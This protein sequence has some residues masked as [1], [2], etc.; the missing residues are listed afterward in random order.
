MEEGELYCKEKKVREEGSEVAGEVAILDYSDDERELFDEMRVRG[1]HFYFAKVLPIENPKMDAMIKKAE[2]TIEKINRDQVVMTQKIRERMMDRDALRSKLNRMNCG[3]YELALKWKRNSLDFLYPSLDKLT[4]ANNAYRGKSVNSCLSVGEVDKQKLCFLMVHGCKNMGD[5]RKL[6]R[7]VDAMQGKDGGMTLDE[8][9]APIQ[10]LQQRLSINYVAHAEIDENAHS[11][12]ILNAEKQHE[13]IRETA[14]ANA[15]VNGKLW[16]SL[17]SK[18]SIQQQVQEL[19]NRSCELR[20]R[21]REVNAK[22]KKVNKEVKMIEKDIGSLQKVFTY[23]NRKKDEA[24]NT[25]LRLKRQYGEENASYYQYRSLMRKVQ[26]L[27]KKKDTAAIQELS[28]TQVDKFMQQWNNN[29]DFRND[30]KKRVV[31]RLNNRHLGVDGSMITNQKAEV[32]DSKKAPKPEA[33]S[34]AR[35]K[36]LM[37]DPEDPSELFFLVK[38]RR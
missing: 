20:E 37:K 9:R 10:H 23:A 35:L 12:L 3:N 38:L 17:G 8:L 26:V 16:N 30:Y 18:K 31:P 33:L 2:E 14:L 32:K 27:G 34:K 7:E 29:L 24:Y 5:E 28:Q 21:Q 22:V 25:I 1:R 4:F 36:W 6:L 19:N 15:V 11:E 13:I